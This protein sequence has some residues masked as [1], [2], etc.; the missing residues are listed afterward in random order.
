MAR[1]AAVAVAVAVGC[2][3]LLALAP[4]GQAQKILSDKDVDRIAKQWDDVRGR[5]LRL[6]RPG[7]A[8]SGSPY[9][10]RRTPTTA[11]T[12]RTWRC[13]SSRCAASRTR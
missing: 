10:D 7:P 12:C 11:W 9:S 3:V 2:L 4:P 13:S 8:L 1:Q 6:S 5:A